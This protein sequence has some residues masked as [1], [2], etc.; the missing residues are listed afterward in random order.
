M[1]KWIKVFSAGKLLDSNLFPVYTHLTGACMCAVKSI[2]RVN[3]DVSGFRFVS[4]CGS[5][6]LKVTFCSLLPQFK[7]E[8]TSATAAKLS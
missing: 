1:L 4:A 2:G 7:L 8:H 5:F 3:A 6:K